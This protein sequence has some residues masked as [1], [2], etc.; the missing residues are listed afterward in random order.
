MGRV[1]DSSLEDYHRAL[2]MAVDNAL[3]PHGR[4]AASLHEERGGPIVWSLDI[5]PT[6]D[7]AAKSYVTHIGGDE[8]VLGFG[9]THVYMW[10][11]NPEELARQVELLLTGIFNGS[12]VEAGPRKDAFALVETTE[13]QVGVGRMH[14]PWPWRLRRTRRY[15]PYSPPKDVAK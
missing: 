11:D 4:G 5:T 7:G 10:H 2:R 1:Q 15:A 9:G 14:M 6:R 13:G 3:A 12:F 8:I